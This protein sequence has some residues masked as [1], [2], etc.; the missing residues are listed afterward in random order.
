MKKNTLT[1]IGKLKDGDIFTKSGSDVQYMKVAII[2]VRKYKM[3]FQ[4]AAVP[5][6]KTEQ[7]FFH[8]G[9]EVIYLFT[10]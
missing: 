4:Y 10:L 1:T 5:V 8:A 2:P 3:I 6:G 9:T 7:K